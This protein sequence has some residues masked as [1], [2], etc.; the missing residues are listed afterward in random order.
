[1]SEIYK[2]IHAYLYARENKFRVR[3]VPILFDDL[4]S[5]SINLTSK[6]IALKG[7]DAPLAYSKWLESY[8]FNVCR[9]LSDEE[10]QELALDRIV[11][12]FD[13]PIDGFLARL[14]KFT[15]EG[16]LKILR[17]WLIQVKN[18]LISKFGPFTN[19][20]RKLENVK[21]YGKTIQNIQLDLEFANA[22]IDVRASNIQVHVVDHARALKIIAN[23]AIK[24]MYKSLFVLNLHTGYLTRYEF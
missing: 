23:A 7:N 15:D 16:H 22:F 19:I 13:T 21:Y 9:G 14:K 8:F 5:R 1:M 11:G 10:C 2:D 12:K 24:P 20:E 4:P 3:Y 18:Y 17:I 6:M